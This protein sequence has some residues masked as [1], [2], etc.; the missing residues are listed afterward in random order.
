MHALR[1][2][3][4]ALAIPFCFNAALSQTSPYRYG[5]KVEMVDLYASVYNRAGKLVKGLKREDFILYDDGVQQPISQF[6]REYVPLSVL[7]LLDDSGSMSGLKLDSARRSLN[8]FLKRLNRGDEAML[9]T[10]Q[11]RPHI[12]QPFTQDMEKIRNKLKRLEGNGSTALYDAVLQSLDVIQQSHNPRRTL[13]LISD[14]INTFGRSALKD[15]ITTLRRSGVELYAIGIESDSPDERQ[16]KTVT[17]AVLNQ[18]TTSAGGEAFMIGDA[19][20]LATVC[21]SISD[22]MHN[23]Y[24]LGYYP[25]KTNEGQWRNIRVVTRAPGMTVVPSKRGYFSSK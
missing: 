23:Q 13:L 21:R 6:S 12:E 9:M 11:A 24:S 14:G 20:D 18:L 25:P 5:V 22:Q 2:F 7:I 3:T 16:E 8:Q 4:L 17:Q 19:T 15:T 1:M 10:F